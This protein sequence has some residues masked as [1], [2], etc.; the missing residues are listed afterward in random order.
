M[1]FNF[2]K[3]TEPLRGD[4]LLFTVKFPGVPGTHLID[5]GQMKDWVDNSV[6]LNSKSLNSDYLLF[7]RQREPWDST[8]TSEI[9]NVI[10]NN[11]CNI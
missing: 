7:Q 4:I 9:E 1:G 3:A 6:V 11:L 10:K 2:I 8:V 5:L